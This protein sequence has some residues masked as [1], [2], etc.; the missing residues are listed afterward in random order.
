VYCFALAALY[1]LHERRLFVPGPA[2]TLRYFVERPAA[3]AALESALEGLR[4]AGYLLENDTLLEGGLAASLHVLADPV[5]RL[6]VVRGTPREVPRSVVTDSDGVVGV[7]VLT[8][9]LEVVISLTQPLADVAAGV[10]RV[11]TG[12]G[13]PERGARLDVVGAEAHLLTAL[14]PL[15]R[16]SDLSADR[17]VAFVTALGGTVSHEAAVAAL[18]ELCQAGWLERRDAAFA[19]AAGREER[20]AALAGDEFVDI[21][22][23]RFAPDREL[24]RTHRFH[25]AGAG[26]WRL[27]PFVAGHDHAPAET[28]SEAVVGQ[29]L[30]GLSYIPQ[31]R[32]MVA[33]YVYGLLG[34]AR[35]RSGPGPRSD[36]R[37]A[38]RGIRH[39]RR[40]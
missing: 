33:D 29:C 31:S 23:T 39:S 6:R 2:S 26:V 36:D 12:E 1:G 14:A 25:R 38:G 28:A 16:V 7:S 13:E 3:P 17:L 11:V 27:S 15:L 32:E 8:D 34:L 21:V 9:G 18:A 20:L 30:L 10:C 37:R 22:L 5:L 40:S 4:E 35:P 19:L 24:R